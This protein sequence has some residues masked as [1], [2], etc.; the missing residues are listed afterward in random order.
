MILEEKAVEVAVLPKIH[1]A[2]AGLAA[3]CIG[4]QVDETGE[5]CCSVC[6]KFVTFEKDAAW[7]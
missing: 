1:G 5:W 3:T 7:S 4:E 2:G 6:L